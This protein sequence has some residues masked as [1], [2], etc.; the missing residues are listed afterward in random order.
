MPHDPLAGRSIL[1]L[2]PHLD[3]AVFSASALLDYG[4]AE[5]WTV[6]AGIPD[7]GIVTE[8]D[9]RSGYN[10]GAELI[11]DRRAEDDAA[12]HGVPHHQLNI[13]ERAYSSPAAQRVALEG[14]IA[15]V[16]QWARSHPDGIVAIPAGAGAQVKDAW[17]RGLRH[18]A[19]KICGRTS[20]V[21][22]S[23][24]AT[25][26][27]DGGRHTYL[28]RFAARACRRAQA[29]LHADYMRRRRHA[30]QHGMLANEDHLLLR[31]A[32]VGARMAISA[33]LLFYEE[34]PYAWSLPADAEMRRLL[35]AENGPADLLL[36]TAQRQ[37]K[38]ARIRLY[39]TQLVVMDPT[40][41]R[42][43]SVETIPV[44][45]RYWLLARSVGAL[46]GDSPAVSVV[47]PTYNGVR[48]LGMQL[49]ALAEQ[50][51]PPP[52]EVIVVDN[53]SDAD[54]AAV[55]A[56]FS[57]ELELRLLLADAHQGVAYA[58]NVGIAAAR[59]EYLGFCD[60]DDVVDAHWVRGVQRALDRAPLVTGTGIEFPDA[61]FTSV[62]DIRSA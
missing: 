23:D 52:F 13:P 7:E 20:A 24:D 57:A 43:T 26:A 30:Q 61:A 48:T 62:Q 38:F 8:W 2:S 25:P 28:H 39:E 19:S 33:D 17:Y 4:Q 32:V 29:V 47:I 44:D 27:G 1:I 11:R 45:E 21:A 22:S 12:L 50:S 15:E 34:F 59:S 55:T 16:A 6:F 14:V 3:D 40:L 10:S 49:Q 54:V 5:V 36:R 58:R 37:R 60:D 51:D 18:W 56:S 35:R 42:L 53:G 31:D 9:R 41:G 46:D